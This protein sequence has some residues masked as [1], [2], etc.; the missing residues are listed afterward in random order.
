MAN[1]SAHQLTSSGTETGRSHR[2][3][4]GSLSPAQRRRRSKAPVRCGSTAVRH[5]S[6]R[7]GSTSAAALWLVAGG[8]SR[9]S[10]Q[11][12]AARSSAC[13]TAAGLTSGFVAPASGLDGDGPTS[14][15]GT[16]SFQQ[17]SAG[18]GWAR[19]SVGAP[20]HDGPNGRLRCEC[21]TWQGSYSVRQRCW[22]VLAVHPRRRR[23]L[24]PRRQL[25]PRRLPRRPPRPLR[26]PGV[27]SPPGPRPRCPPC[28]H[29]LQHRLKHPHLSPRPSRL[30][31]PR[32]RAPTSR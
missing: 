6:I 22:V 29:R 4:A 27:S 23:L 11:V 13:C 20:A 18:A 2:T 7:L 16:A 30:S 24:R 5:R 26:Q 19:R 28:R 21:A 1:R 12:V 8:L 31:R 3:S 9:R 25:R 14:R 32:R 15:S 17:K 10:D